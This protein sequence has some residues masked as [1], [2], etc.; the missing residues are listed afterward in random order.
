MNTNM[1]DLPT[2]LDRVAGDPTP[3]GVAEIYEQAAD[4]VYLAGEEVSP[5]VMELLPVVVEY[6]KVAPKDWLERAKNLV[7]YSGGAWECE[8]G[9][10]PQEEALWLRDDLITGDLVNKVAELSGKEWKPC[11][12][13]YLAHAAIWEIHRDRSVETLRELLCDVGMSVDMWNE[14]RDGESAREILSS[15]WWNDALRGAFAG[16]GD[17]RSALDIYKRGRDELVNAAEFENPRLWRRSMAD[18]SMF[19]APGWDEDD[20]Q[21][22]DRASFALLW[23]FVENWTAAHAGRKIGVVTHPEW[24]KAASTLSKDAGALRILAPGLRKLRKAMDLVTSRSGG[25]KYSL[26]FMDDIIADAK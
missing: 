9:D 7:Y 12:E 17:L 1:N 18:F 24:L 13:Y 22:I 4:S 21:E 25:V 20:A 10:T 3:Y 11:W 14:Y 15:V 23:S 19:V 26:W 8:F 5:R 2:L 6:N 16:D